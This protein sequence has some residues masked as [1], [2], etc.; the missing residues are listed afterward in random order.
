MAKSETLAMF[1]KEAACEGGFFRSGHTKSV[2]LE[3]GRDTGQFGVEGRT[4]RIDR[5]DDHDRNAG[6][7]QTVFNCGPLRKEKT[8]EMLVRDKVSRLMRVERWVGAM[9]ALPPKADIK[10]VGRNVC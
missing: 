2:L 8:F 5:S 7:D 3:L 4:N 1:N 6:G 9:S 10:S